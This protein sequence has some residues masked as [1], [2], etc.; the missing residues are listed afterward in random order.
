MRKIKNKYNSS[1]R[2]YYMGTY[3]HNC[4]KV[5]YKEHIHPQ[6]LLCPI[7]NTYVPLTSD[8]K[9]KII[10]DKLVQLNPDSERGIICDSEKLKEFLE[11][12]QLI[13][14]DFKILPM[15]RIRKT[16]VEQFHTQFESLY[17]VMGDMLLEK[18]LFE[19]RWQS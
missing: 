9:E 16:L 7:T 10:K 19:R 15:K 17:K 13:D 6:H 2:Y 3:I 11:N 4:Q 5:K 14:S 18:F 8:V 12:F 1:M